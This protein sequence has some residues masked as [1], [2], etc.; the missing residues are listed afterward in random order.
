MQTKDK[1]YVEDLFRF[2]KRNVARLNMLEKGLISDEDYILGAINYTKKLK[3]EGIKCN[4]KI[5][6]DNVVEL[7][8]AEKEELR[9]MINLTDIMFNSLTEKQQDIM[10]NIYFERRPYIDIAY[11]LNY[12]DKNSI[13]DNKERILKQLLELFKVIKLGATKM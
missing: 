9:D 13:W 5:S 6:L 8:E 4:V 11:E 2:Y 12:R 1:E 7:R 10:K 3:S